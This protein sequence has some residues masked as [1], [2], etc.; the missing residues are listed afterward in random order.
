MPKLEMLL[1]IAPLCIACLKQLLPEYSI[2]ILVSLA[3]LIDNIPM[4]CENL[5]LYSTPQFHHFCSILAVSYAAE[6]PDQV[7]AG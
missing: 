6:I 1:D 7:V 5:T 2:F 3:V 4:N